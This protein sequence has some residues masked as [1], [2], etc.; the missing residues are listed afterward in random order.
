MQSQNKVQ[1]FA[2]SE[3]FLLPLSEDEQVVV[4]GGGGKHRA[5]GPKHAKPPTAIGR[6]LG[7]GGRVAA[8]AVPGLGAVSLAFDAYQA[9]KW[10]S[11]SSIHNKKG[12][13][14]SF[15]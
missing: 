3:E 13:W 6:A 15:L 8:K 1:Q 14:W 2:T 10:Y 5:P 4:T 11:K 7:I 12:E 9:G